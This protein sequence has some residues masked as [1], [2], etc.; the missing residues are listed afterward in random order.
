[1]SGVDFKDLETRGFVLIPSFLSDAE[2]QICREDFA[3]Q[4]VST[5]NR[6]YNLSPVRGKAH[7]TVQERVRG[8]LA[9]VATSTNLR[10]NLP[11][12]ASYFATGR[13]IHFSWHQDHE[14]FFSIQN[15]YD[16]LNFYIPINKPRKDKSNLCIVPFDVLEKECPE[17]FRKLARGGAARFESMGDRTMVFL[18]DTGSVHVMCKDLEQLAQAPELDPGDLLLM[19]GDMIHRTQD[20]ETERVSLSFRAANSETVVHRS[21]LADGGPAKAWMM[22]N[23]A[24]TYERMF[25]AFDAAGQ[26]AVPFAELQQ[27]MSSVRDSDMGRKR[28]F[29]YLLR[30]KRRERVLLR[31]FRASLTT[32]A[33]RLVVGFR[34]RRHRRLPATDRSTAVPASVR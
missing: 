7:E 9:R 10:A 27:A 31:F 20:T 33:A 23:A 18:D 8:V 6:N 28:F 25:L 4:P 3:T 5:N 11:L 22:M 24:D 32:M 26:K 29:R 15:H 30:Q 12:E 14:S 21:R 13:G 16:Y 19:R 2:L 1:M 34:Q 17:T